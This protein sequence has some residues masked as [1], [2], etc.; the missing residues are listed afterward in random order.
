M[1]TAVSTNREWLNSC[2]AASSLVYP[3][4]ARTTI[5]SVLVP[6]ASALLVTARRKTSDQAAWSPMRRNITFTC[7]DANG[8]DDTFRNW[9]DTIGRRRVAPSAAS[10]SSQ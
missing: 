8:A 3:T 6:E 5:G 9:N 1:A 2:V 7:T 10:V 4:G